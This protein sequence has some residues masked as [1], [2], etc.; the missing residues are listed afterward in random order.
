VKT[1]IAMLAAVAV[2]AMSTASAG[3]ADTTPA[4]APWA[5]TQAPGPRPTIPNPSPNW[6]RQ[7]TGADLAQYYPDRAQRMEKEGDAIIRCTATLEGSLADCQVVSESPKGYGF[8][9]A[10]VKVARFF[11]VKP[12]MRDGYPVESLITIPL[13]WRLAHTAPAAVPPATQP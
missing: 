12:M 11:R 13:R 5:A 4:P 3:W 6:T 8:G 9:D 1:V 7:A 10:T 2:A